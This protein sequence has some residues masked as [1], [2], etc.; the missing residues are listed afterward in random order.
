MSTSSTTTT[1]TRLRRR[2]LSTPSVRQHSRIPICQP[3]SLS[4]EA[5]DLSSASPTQALASLRFLVLTYLADLERWLSQL[6]SPDLETWRAKGELTVEE[7]RQWAKTALEMLDSIRADVYSHLPE[8]HL[9]DISV[10]NLVKTHLPDLPN[11]PTLRS[12]LPDMP[13]VR[14]HLPDMPNM[15]AHLPDFMTSKF[16][17]VRTRF[18]DLDFDVPLSFVPTLKDRLHSLRSHLSTIELSSKLVMPSSLAPSTM[19]SDLL[20]GLLSSDLLSDLLKS[21]PEQLFE[22]NVFE[23]TAEEI[24]RAVKRSLQGVR[25]ITSADLPQPWRNNPFVLDGY[26]FIPLERWPLILLSLFAFHNETLNI[27]T[28]LIPFILWGA[29]FIPFVD[30]SSLKETPERLFMG[31]ALLCLFSSVVWHTM[32]GCAHHRSVEV[33]AQIDYVGIGWLISASVGTVVYYGFQCNP[34]VGNIFLVFCF[35]TGLAGNICPFMDWFNQYEYRL[36]RIVFFLALAFSAVAPLAALAVLHST[37]EMF[38]FM[39]PVVPSLISYVVGLLFYASHVPERFF[40]EKWR[41]RMD[42]CGGGSHSIWHCFIVLAVSQHKAAI[43]A[44][45]AGIKCPV[46]V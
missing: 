37:R 43:N 26:R 10:E 41:R 12:H 22:E 40:S 4:L 23:K 2:R 13:D 3:L 15:R 1:T 5:L 14:V 30:T 8:F 18:N 11:V 20:D 25:L 16:D 38:A 33:C 27:H 44:L 32:V 36:W 35:L 29:S 9:A 46:R 19:L 24:A 34:S 45:K 21:A 39:A 42:M 31:F 28:H 17:D 6:E 7:A